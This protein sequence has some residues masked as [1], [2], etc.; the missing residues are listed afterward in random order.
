MTLGPLEFFPSIEL[1]LLE[2]V[3]RGQKR[4]GRRALAAATENHTWREYQRLREEVA[5]LEAREGSGG[6]VALVWWRRAGEKL[7]QLGDPVGEVWLSV[8]EGKVDR[9][10]FD[11]AAWNTGRAAKGGGRM[12]PK[13]LSYSG[14]DLKGSYAYRLRFTAEEW[15][16]LAELLVD[17]PHDVNDRA[18]EALKGWAEDIAQA[19]DLEPRRPIYFEAPQDWADFLW[20]VLT[21]PSAGDV[22]DIGR[23]MRAQVMRINRET[24]H[25]NRGR[26]W[27]SL[28][29]ER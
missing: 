20:Y 21:L 11:S 8:G 27:E 4:A 24:R 16:C 2:M 25:R 9:R 10:R 22:E 14:L 12:I 23:S 5:F 18:R 15:G 26:Y 6:W 29:R 19:Y 3:T 1:A 7:P 13:L 28:R 17:A